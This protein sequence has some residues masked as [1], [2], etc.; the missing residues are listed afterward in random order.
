MRSIFLV[1]DRNDYFDEISSFLKSQNIS[2]NTLEHSS[3]IDQLRNVHSKLPLFILGSYDE[4]LIIKIKNNS[5]SPKFIL[6]EKDFKNLNFKKIPEE[7]NIFLATEVLK[8]L[9]DCSFYY[10][11]DVNRQKDFF[12]L[13]D[14]FPGTKNFFCQTIKHPSSKYLPISQAID[15][16]ADLG[17]FGHKLKALEICMDEIIT[18]AFMHTDPESTD[19]NIDF[20]W[21]YNHEFFGFSVTDYFGGL[22][23]AKFFKTILDILNKNPATFNAEDSSFGLGYYNFFKTLHVLII[24]VE[25][26][27]KTQIIGLIDPRIKRNR[28]H[29]HYN[30]KSILFFHKD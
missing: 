15:L 17:I 30:V 9:S 13:K 1:K 26:G 11:L 24:N 10:A 4:D 29:K 3:K 12:E 28:N 6:I 5:D 14:I 2:F 7:I 8:N 19:K 25:P 16:S 23:R 27:K 21:G 22:Q 18:N 20:A